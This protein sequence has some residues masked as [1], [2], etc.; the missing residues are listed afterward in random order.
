[1]SIRDSKHG[2]KSGGRICRP[3][4][5]ELAELAEKL[6]SIPASEITCERSFAIQNYICTSRSRRARHDLINAR[7]KLMQG[8]G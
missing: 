4:L 6:L 5:Q 7:V 1:M 8:R 2:V 3:D